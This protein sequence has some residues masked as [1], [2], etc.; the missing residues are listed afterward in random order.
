MKQ[1][2]VTIPPT[3]YEDLTICVAIP[4]LEDVRTFS[5]Q[6]HAVGKPWVGFF[7]GWDG[8]YLPSEPTPPP[9]SKMTFT[10]AEFVLGDSRVWFLAACGKMATSNH[11]PR[12][13]A[14]QQHRE[15]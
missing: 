11:L 7:Q 8:E 1:T 9:G 5:D 13:V 10:P 14:V 4:D 2:T 6:L 15:L 3:E 12:R